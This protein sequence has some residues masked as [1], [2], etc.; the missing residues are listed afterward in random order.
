MPLVGSHL[1][2][3]Q[4]FLNDLKRFLEAPPEVLALVHGTQPVGASGYT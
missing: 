2:R 4:P 3:K 1:G